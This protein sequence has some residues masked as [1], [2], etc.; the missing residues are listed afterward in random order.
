MRREG[1]E[2]RPITERFLAA[3]LTAAARTELER[4]MALFDP[5]VVGGRVIKLSCS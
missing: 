5:G 2:G 1:R 3:G 4:S